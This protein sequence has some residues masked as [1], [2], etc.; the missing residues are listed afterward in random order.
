[1]RRC[2]RCVIPD[3]AEG[4]TF[5][6][7]GECNICQ[8]FT[9]HSVLG[10]DVL[11][12][13]IKKHPS[14]DSK[15][16]CIIPVSGGR[17]SS[18]ALYFAKEKLGL[19]PLAVHNDNDFETKQAR[20]NL[21]AIT[22]SLEVDCIQ[23][24]SAANLSKK[25]VREKMEMNAP[26]GLD[27]VVNQTCEACEYGFESAAHNIALKKGIKLIFWGDSKN[28]STQSYHDLVEQK[29]PGNI[30]KLFSSGIINRFKYHYYFKR[31]KE[32]YGPK[33]HP[34]LHPVHL[35]DYIKWDR[36]VIVS[37]IENKLGWSKPADSVTTWRT[38]C[39]LVPLVSYLYTKSYGVS[40][41]ELGFSN[42]IRDN[43]MS[44]EKALEELEQMGKNFDVIELEL[45][46][47][48]TGI[49]EKT[50]QKI[51]Y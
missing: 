12:Q 34:G 3:T 7:K 6:A 35:F 24:S 2:K 29:M 22:S 50:I 51:L 9:P 43:K 44:R 11:K 46:L 23:T 31:L 32:E 38:D 17:D 14:K 37:T 45:L 21:K 41:I 39:K 15:Y 30:S 5:N 26:F 19:N 48:E 28:E 13:E 47:R 36:R 16:D 8:N 10:I 18:Y 49:T 42:M 1:M 27:L 25:I 20:R 4:I 33:H 40:K